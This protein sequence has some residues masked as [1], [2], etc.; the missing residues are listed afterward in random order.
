MKTEALFPQPEST[1]PEPQKD[2]LSVGIATYKATRAKTR[3]CALCVQLQV[4][5]QGVWGPRRPVSWVRTT[6]GGTDYLCGPHAAQR[7]DLETS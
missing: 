5:T 3:H 4:E 7:M 6:A 1:V 2:P